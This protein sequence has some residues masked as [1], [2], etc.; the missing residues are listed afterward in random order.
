M[1]EAADLLARAEHPVIFAGGGVARSQAQGELVTLAEHLGAPVLTTPMGKGVIPED[2]RLAA[3]VSIG[4]VAR[5]MCEAADVMLAVGCRFTEVA[6]HGWSLPVPQKLIHVDVDPTPFGQTYPPAVTVLGDAKLV[7]AALEEAVPADAD[8]AQTQ[9]Q[10]LHEL[11]AAERAEADGWPGAYLIRPLR[12][13]LPREGIV[14][15]DVGTMTYWMYPRFASYEP[16]TF[17]T[18]AAYITMGWGV[19]AAAGAKL[20][21]PERP[22]VAVTG[23]GGF[24]MSCQ[25]LATIAAEGIAVTIVV[26]NDRSLRTV[27][28]IQ[29]RKFEGRRYATTLPGPD[30]V[31]LAE[32]FGVAAERVEGDDGIAAA[33]ERGLSRGG[34]YLVELKREA[35]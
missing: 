21:A 20:A 19:P 11:W 17:L 8:R 7:L 32:S 10:R 28:Q 12:E 22:V 34:P 27:A 1:E 6:T 24:L 13:V 33:L 3:S 30:F 29:E 26:V 25:E 35:Y 23:D 14:A 4:R 5:A 31:T 18:A 2:H 15:C 16:N 9:A